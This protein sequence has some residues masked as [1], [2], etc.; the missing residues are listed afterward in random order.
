MEGVEYTRRS[1]KPRRLSSSEYDW[2]R[3]EGRCF[4]CKRIGHVSAACTEDKDLTKKERNRRTAVLKA[5]SSKTKEQKKSRKAQKEE[6]S[7]E[8]ESNRVNTLEED[9]DLG[10]D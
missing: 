3:R 5:S 6:L 10:K 8:E 2:L 1:G 7:S 4:N 9:S